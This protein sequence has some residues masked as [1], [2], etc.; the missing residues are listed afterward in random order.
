MDMSDDN[1]ISDLKEGD[2]VEMT[3]DTSTNSN[4][5]ASGAELH[6]IDFA[7][8]FPQNKGPELIE[9]YELYNYRVSGNFL[10]AINRKKPV[11]RGKES[12]Y[13]KLMDEYNEQ[14]NK[15]K[16]TER[17]YV[18]LDRS[19]KK[20]FKEIC[21]SELAQ[22]RLP[23]LHN[24]KDVKVYADS[25]QSTPTVDIDATVQ[26]AI[27]ILNVDISTD[28][29]E[30]NS[31]K[32][33]DQL[34]IDTIV[35][36]GERVNMRNIRRVIN[37]PEFLCRLDNRRSILPIEF[38][39][40]LDSVLSVE[41]TYK[42]YVVQILKVKQESKKKSDITKG[43]QTTKNT[44]TI[45]KVK[46]QT[47]TRM[48]SKEDQ[49]DVDMESDDENATPEAKAVRQH[50]VDIVCNE[51]KDLSTLVNPGIPRLTIA[52]IVNDSAYSSTVFNVETTEQINNR[53]PGYLNTVVK[54]TEFFKGL[55][56]KHIKK[57][58]VSL[59]DLTTHFNYYL[60]ELSDLFCCVNIAGEETIRP[61][62]LAILGTACDTQ[63]ALVKLVEDE[64]VMYKRIWLHVNND[65]SQADMKEE[66]E[67][68]QHEDKRAYLTTVIADLKQQLEDKSNSDT[69]SLISTSEQM[70][71]ALANIGDRK[72]REDELIIFERELTKITEPT[73]LELKLRAVKMELKKAEAKTKESNLKNPIKRPSTVPL[74]EAAKEKRNKEWSTENDELKRREQV[75]KR[76][77]VLVTNRIELIKNKDNIS[78]IYGLDDESIPYLFELPRRR[79][80]IEDNDKTIQEILKRWGISANKYEMYI[81]TVI[82]PTEALVKLKCDIEEDFV[83]RVIGVIP[84]E[85]GETDVATARKT[86]FRNK[87]RDAGC[88]YYISKETVLDIVEQSIEELE[89]RVIKEE[90][91]DKYWDMKIKEESDDIQKRMYKQ[92]K[93]DGEVP[94]SN[95]LSIDLVRY[96]VKQIEML[97]EYKLVDDKTLED[98]HALLMFTSEYDKDERLWSYNLDNMKSLSDLN[99]VHMMQDA[100]TKV[101]KNKWYPKHAVNIAVSKNEHRF[102][103]IQTSDTWDKFQE[104]FPDASDSEES[105]SESEAEDVKPKY[106]TNPD[107][108]PVLDIEGN[109]TLAPESEQDSAID[110]D[111]DGKVGVW[112]EEFKK[113]SNKQDSFA[114]TKQRI[115]RRQGKAH[116]ERRAHDDLDAQVHIQKAHPSS[117][118]VEVNRKLAVGEC[119]HELKE[120]LVPGMIGMYEQMDGEQKHEF[121]GHV[122]T[123]ALRNAPTDVLTTEAMTRNDSEIVTGLRVHNT[124]IQLMRTEVLNNNNIS[125]APIVQSIQSNAQPMATPVVQTKPRLNIVR[126]GT[127]NNNNNSNNNTS[128]NMDTSNDNKQQELTRTAGEAELP[129]TNKAPLKK[130]KTQALVIVMLT[131]KERMMLRERICN[132][133]LTDL[134]R[135]RPVPLDSDRI[136][137]I[138]MNRYLDIYNHQ[139]CLHSHDD[140][141]TDKDAH[142]MCVAKMVDSPDPVNKGKT[143]RQVKKVY[144]PMQFFVRFDT[145]CGNKGCKRTY[146]SQPGQHWYVCQSCEQKGCCTPD[147]YKEFAKGHESDCI[148]ARL[149]NM[150]IQ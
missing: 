54:L 23:I 107:G 32:Y 85:D 137:H 25:A 48:E 36:N 53:G 98:F 9:F 64:S 22:F 39:T 52:E 91:Y 26:W 135:A 119:K 127:S 76:K 143:I 45:D 50:I 132:P 93:K 16:V 149:K 61:A 15:D 131:D 70:Q 12:S 138:D 31:Q 68:K 139:D 44:K 84:R 123:D 73:D 20:I 10:F 77:Q 72:V 97:M 99:I 80:A 75:I 124:E 150:N 55:L 95:T 62:D 74:T 144:M 114:R 37:I 148:I 65:K 30:V 21:D 47:N 100:M 58:A 67:D 14:R 5:G 108:S 136:H 88:T 92:S 109:P 116:A 11:K 96:A 105:D 17:T 140:D 94:D 66:V 82:C 111:D 18:N 4:V 1:D 110:K 46:A 117:L 56:A 90:K 3:D 113:R 57:D 130:P 134:G 106:K 60:D 145:E 79:E 112:S 59:I 6:P 78:N 51:L 126:I 142:V 28:T 104:E 87:E 115:D 49:D 27:R 38:W 133:R 121:L 141:P 125:I 42:P 120:V 40:K 63:Q 129:D 19:T 128:N 147:C 146:T 103:A 2:D 34:N 81:R 7:S 71:Q 35:I 29:A 102:T 8:V 86:F 83:N 41:H 118:I 24:I 122:Q 69:H 13:N 43:S 33:K 89:D 101:K